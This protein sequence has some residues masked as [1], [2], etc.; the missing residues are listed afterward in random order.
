MTGSGEI[1]E[2]MPGV[3]RVLMPERGG[4][5]VCLPEGFDSPRDTECVVQLDYGEDVG[6]V[7]WSGRYSP[8]LHGPRIPGFR[9]IRPLDPSDDA[10]L[11]ANADLAESMCVTFQKLAA[12]DGNDI[13]ILHRRLSFGRGRLFIRFKSERTR[14]DLARPCAEIRR[15]FNATVNA[16]QLGP[17]DEVSL[18]GALGPCGRACCCCDWQMRYPQGLTAGRVRAMGVAPGG[19]NGICGRFK[20]C[21]AFEDADSPACD[22]TA[23]D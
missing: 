5:L 18:A 8:E 15:L 4:V 6:V 17:R 2:G 16:W 21:L 19:Q 1:A 20:C 22:G 14:P 10:R 9:L 13:D 7:K 12:A 11:A 23:C 3:A